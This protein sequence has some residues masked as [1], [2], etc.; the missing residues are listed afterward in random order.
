MRIKLKAAL[1]EITEEAPVSAAP[2]SS[3][4]TLRPEAH[5]DLCDGSCSLLDTLWEYILTVRHRSEYVSVGFDPRVGPRVDR[6]MHICFDLIDW[7]EI[8]AARSK[9]GCF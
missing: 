9:P 5:T 3:L 4:T 6:H 2:E 7:R 8:F 1:K